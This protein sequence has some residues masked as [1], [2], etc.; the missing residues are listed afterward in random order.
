M[1][2]NLKSVLAGGLV[3]GALD[4]SFATLYAASHGVPPV[5]VLLS[6]A[7]G[8][9][10]NAAYMGGTDMPGAGL[11]FHFALAIGWAALFV[12]LARRVRYVH[13]N[14]LSSGLV[15]GAFV[16]LAMRLVV[17]PLSAYPKP[18]QFALPGSLYDLL[19]HL[20]LFGLPIALSYR[21]FAGR[22]PF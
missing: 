6:I 5:L 13:D 8:V 3:G 19:S 11:S 15:F 9:F 14:A 22:V 7:S 10:G 16:F 1:S 2:P 4:L 18:V 12:W 21:R 17:L 20:F